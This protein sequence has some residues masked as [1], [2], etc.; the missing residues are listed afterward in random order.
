MADHVQDATLRSN[1]LY[2]AAVKQSESLL[3]NGTPSNQILKK[4]YAE[5]NDK[6]D[7]ELVLHRNNLDA[8]YKQ[9]DKLTKPINAQHDIIITMYKNN[10]KESLEF[11]VKN[12][13]DSI[14]NGAKRIEE[15]EITVE[16]ILKD[17]LRRKLLRELL[18]EAAPEESEKLNTYLATC[19]EI[20][21]LRSKYNEEKLSN[22]ERLRRNKEI[23]KKTISGLKKQKDLRDAEN[24]PDTE[25]ATE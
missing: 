3:K 24:E 23:T 10:M 17:R 16:F 5:F 1:Q 21:V 6:I 2:I 12:R 11:Y 8:V 7:A 14:Q 22:E 19:I 15:P 13:I 18:E 4:V 25:A 9:E 20:D